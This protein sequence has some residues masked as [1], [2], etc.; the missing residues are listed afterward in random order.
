MDA[1]RAREFVRANSRAVLTTFRA[2]GRPQLSPVTVGV[3]AEGR[4]IVSS[5]ETAVKVRNLRRDPRVAACVFTE[6]FFGDWVQVEGAAEVVPLPEAMELL[7][8]YYRRLAG[9]HPDWDDY[10]SAMERERRVLVRFAIERAG[11]DVS[12]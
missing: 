1:E 2:D 7:V 6:G 10:R 4:V 3:D 9:E 8:D 5:R 11:P 12:G